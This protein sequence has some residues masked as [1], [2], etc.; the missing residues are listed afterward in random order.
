MA[1]I[2][3]GIGDIARRAA[4]DRIAVAGAAGVFRRLTG[5]LLAAGD[6]GVDL[7]GVAADRAKLALRLLALLFTG[8]LVLALLLVG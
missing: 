2:I 4:A 1:R 7:T 3:A 8:L 6:G 5:D